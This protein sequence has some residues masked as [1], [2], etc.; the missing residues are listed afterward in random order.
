MDAYANFLSYFQIEKEALFDW[1]IKQ[2]IFPPVEAVEREWENLKK[3]IFENQRV[4]IRGYGRNAHGTYLYQGLYA[5]VFGN[6]QIQKDPTNNA[7]CHKLIER[8]T[9]LK[10]NRDI[11]N[12]QVSH[13]W[14]HTKNP[15]FFEAPWNLCYTPKLMDPFTGHESK[16]IWPEEYQKIFLAKAYKLYAPFLEDY[17]RVIQD[18]DM[19]NQIKKYV[20][21]L[22]EREEERVLNQFER[23][24]LREWKCI[25]ID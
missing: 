11:Y 25:K 3:R 7:I 22:G 4:Y 2:T 21:S 15:F 18:Y 16:G 23:D 20:Q 5:T 8:L 19:E 13:I 24:A 9:G 17:E 12:Y 10:R 1:G 14:G 6:T